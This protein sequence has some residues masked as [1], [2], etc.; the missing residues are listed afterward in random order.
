MDQARTRRRTLSC[1]L[2][3][4][5]S[6]FGLDLGDGVC[7]GLGLGIGLVLDTLPFSSLSLFLGPLGCLG[8]LCERGTQDRPQ[9]RQ[10][11]I[12]FPT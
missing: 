11:S 4:H 5:G 1:E 3:L 6:L 9:A 2:G 10:R 12:S 7:G 8:R